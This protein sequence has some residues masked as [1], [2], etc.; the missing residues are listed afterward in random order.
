MQSAPAGEEKERAG[1]QGR[2][3][4]KIMPHPLRVMRPYVHLAR[5]DN[6]IA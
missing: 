3:P 2:F 6:S 4:E 5:A 1:S